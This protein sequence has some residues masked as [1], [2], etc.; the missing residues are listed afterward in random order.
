L[1]ANDNLII[2]AL[3]YFFEAGTSTPMSVYSSAGLGSANEHPHPVVADG[4]ARWPQVFFDDTDPDPDNPLVHGRQFYRVRVTDASGVLIYD[5]DGVP[6]I[7][8]TPGEGGGGGVPVDQTALAKTGD[9]KMKFCGATD[10]ADEGWVRCNGG[11]IS[12]FGAG[13]SELDSDAT[14][15]LYS[16]LWN[17]FSF[18]TNDVIC[19]VLGAG[20]HHGASAIAD[21][22]NGIKLTLP[23]MRGRAPFGIDIMGIE[24]GGAGI[25]ANLIA[26][27]YVDTVVLP[28]PGITTARDTCGAVGGDD[29]IALATAQMPAHSHNA[30]GV[31]LWAGPTPPATVALPALTAPNHSHP[32]RTSAS[33]GDD[34]ISGNGG[35]TLSTAAALTEPAW[36]GPPGIGVPDDIIGHQLGGA[37]PLTITGNTGLTGGTNAVPAGNA[38]AHENMPPFFL[39]QFQIKL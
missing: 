32:L 37:G 5:D 26:P 13:G 29:E 10:P 39:I 21:F 6:I 38:S 8:T 17:K 18:P 23:D 12:K 11:T 19:K 2:G 3:A 4:N 7:G 1:D 24:S 22:N 25:G 31:P 30:N 9:V 14:Q 20:G 33:D 16:Y 15:T 34:I 35:V 36:D 28:G 27:G